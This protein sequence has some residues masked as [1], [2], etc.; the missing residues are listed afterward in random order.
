MRIFR[1][2]EADEIQKILEDLIV[3]KMLIRRDVIDEHSFLYKKAKK[4]MKFFPKSN[5]EE[6]I[7]NHNKKKIKHNETK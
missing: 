4:V 7:I 6:L 3:S 5:I 2:K 1:Q